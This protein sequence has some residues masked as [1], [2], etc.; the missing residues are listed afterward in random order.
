LIGEVKTGR[1]FVQAQKDRIVALEAQ[2]GAEQKNSASL[3]SSYAAA[4]REVEQL[5]LAVA[6][7]EQA[8]AL[9]EQ[10][11]AVLMNDNA[12]LKTEAKKSRKHARLA[13]LVAA[14]LTVFILK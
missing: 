1:A 2:L 9:Q 8:I 6:H 3:S 4:T 12:R 5:R 13:M 11:I 14:A 7:Q 10:T